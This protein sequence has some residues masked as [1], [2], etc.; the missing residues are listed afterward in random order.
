MIGSTDENGVSST[1]EYE[2]DKYGNWIRVEGRI[3]DG[4]VSMVAVRE[5]EYNPGVWTG[6]KHQYGSSMSHVSNNSKF[7]RCQ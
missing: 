4:P 7:R 2:F 1:R 3:E 6:G 5:I